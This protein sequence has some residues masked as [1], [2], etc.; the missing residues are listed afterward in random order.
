MRTLVL[1]LLNAITLVLSGVS[2]IMLLFWL[3]CLVTV[4]TG[5]AAGW[6]VARTV[7]QDA[8]REGGEGRETRLPTGK[9][10]LDP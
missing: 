3:L 2:N 6:P 10:V 4:I 1:S 5:V 9:I 8:T 7:P